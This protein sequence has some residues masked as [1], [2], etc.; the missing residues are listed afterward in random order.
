MT[1]AGPQG[2]RCTPR[3]GTSRGC[4]H[5]LESEEDVDGVVAWEPGLG[6]WEIE[7]ALCMRPE[8]KGT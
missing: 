2:T 3:L 4:S 1:E 8:Y 6:Y 5:S 7:P